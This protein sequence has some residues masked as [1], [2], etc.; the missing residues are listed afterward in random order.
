MV[1]SSRVSTGMSISK[2]HTRL[3][4]H[5][6]LS[7]ACPC[8]PSAAATAGRTDAFSSPRLCSTDLPCTRCRL[9]APEPLA[10]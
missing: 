8:C 4:S 7:G 5:A 6:L 9:S 1:F 10:P 2:P 3:R